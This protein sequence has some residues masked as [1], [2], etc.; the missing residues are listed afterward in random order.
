MELTILLI[1]NSV[2]AILS[3]SGG[4]AIG[5]YWSEIKNKCRYFNNHNNNNNRGTHG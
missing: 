2:L 3:F 5:V 4:V 1:I